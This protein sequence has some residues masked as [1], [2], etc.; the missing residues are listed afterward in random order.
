[1]T[2]KLVRQSILQFSS[3]AGEYL[4]SHF[5]TF[6]NVFHSDIGS[7]VT[8]IDIELT[9]I[10]VRR[11]KEIFP[12]HGI[13][14]HGGESINE[15]A[16]CRW[17]ID[18]LDGSSH[19]SRNIPIYTVNIAFQQAGQ[20]IFGA[21]NHPQTHQL[22]FAEKGNG[23]YLNGINIEVS[24]QA[25]L[26]KAFIFVELPERKFSYQPDVAQNFNQNMAVANQLIQ[27]AGQVESFR[28]GAFGQCLVAAGSFDA[29]VDLSGSSQALS[30]AA[31]TL[32]VQEAGGEVIDI[33]E[34]KDGF[35]QF[36]VTNRHLTQTLKDLVLS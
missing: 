36:M 1:M 33:K 21:V 17:I 34:P 26:A 27:Q 35:V 10:L 20:T 29:Y 4:R 7:V 25:N 15:S 3:E 30:Q 12:D 19:F 6:K 16:D 22:F 32:I 18:P 28:I 23:A 24:D 14:V 11:V 13:I 31:S 8:N 2:S 5:Y 9:D